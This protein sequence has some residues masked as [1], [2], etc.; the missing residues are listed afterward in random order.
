MGVLEK[1]IKRNER[2]IKRVRRKINGTKQRPRVA[3]TQ[4]NKHLYVQAIDDTTG[5]TLVFQS[6]LSKEIKTKTKSKKSIQV[7][8]DLA[9]KFYEKLG[10]AKIDTIVLDRRNKQFHGVIKS[11]SDKLR[12]KGVKF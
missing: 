7:A 2:R 10:S 9:E 1:K 4:T 11:F 3:I 5:K 6:T 8:L 12:E